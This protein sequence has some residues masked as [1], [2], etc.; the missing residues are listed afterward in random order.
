MSE[1]V[2]LIPV[3][4]LQLTLDTLEEYCRGRLHVKHGDVFQLFG[5]V[6]AHLES[7]LGVYGQFHQHDLQCEIHE[8][9]E[10]FRNVGSL[11]SYP[12]P[13]SGEMPEA[14]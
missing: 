14:D 5:D 13:L 7:K 8:V 6:A 11:S 1:P 12:I 2:R 4:A 10:M 3:E 9:A